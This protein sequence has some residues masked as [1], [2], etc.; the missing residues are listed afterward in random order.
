[1][2]SLSGV[3]MLGGRSRPTRTAPPRLARTR[4]LP[5]GLARRRYDPGTELIRPGS[6]AMTSGSMR[7]FAKRTCAFCRLPQVAAADVGLAITSVILPCREAWEG[8]AERLVGEAR[9][10]YWAFIHEPVT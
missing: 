5:S 7:C 10:E 9:V 8:I 6:A 2:V 4:P 1:M 3:V